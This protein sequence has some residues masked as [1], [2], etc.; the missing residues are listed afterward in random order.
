MLLRIC[1][2]SAINTINALEGVTLVC[3]FMFLLCFLI[4]IIFDRKKFLKRYSGILIKRLYVLSL[5]FIILFVLLVIFIFKKGNN[6]EG[7]QC[8]SSLN[9]NLLPE[10]N[11]FF[12]KQIKDITKNKVII[13]GDSRMELIVNDANKL[14]IPINFTFIAKSGAAVKWFETDAL[15][16]LRKVLDDI[17]TDYQYHV[18]INMG[19]NDLQENIVINERVVK[20]FEDYL[21]LVERYP[22]VKFYILSVNPINDKK[23]NISQ[24]YNIRTTKSI[25]EF[26]N[27]LINKI[28]FENNENLIYCDSYNDIYFRTTDGIHYKEETNKEILEYIANKCLNYK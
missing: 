26:N 27:L 12:A 11:V 13:V 9:F 7:C 5:I 16:K 10:N 1:D 8:I 6:D 21:G 14:D 24:P 3:F 20:Y 18:V 19:V 25:E 22:K 15:V 23:L 2:E 28:N 4:Y 17:D